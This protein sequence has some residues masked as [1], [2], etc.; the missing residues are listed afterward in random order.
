[1][2]FKLLFWSLLAMTFI[3][4]ADNDMPEKGEDNSNVNQETHPP[5]TFAVISDI[6]FGNN[7]GKGP[8]VKVPQ[9]LR[10]ITSRGELDALI[11][12]GDL[13]E[14]GNISEYDQ[15]VETF[16][17]TTVI[18]NPVKN[19]FFVMGNHDNFNS[20]GKS[21]FQTSLKPFNGGESYPLNNYQVIKGYP[22]IMVSMFDRHNND[23]DYPA[24]GTSTYPA[25][26]TNWLKESLE[27]ASQECP[28]K[29][30]FVFT[31]M[32]PR[33]TIYST[34]PELENGTAWCMKALNPILNKYPQ[35]VV[36]AGHNHYPM[37]DPRSIHQGANPNS[38][39]QN[40]YTVINTSS[41]TYA[42][43]YKDAFDDSIN[44]T[45]PVN[46]ADITEGLIVTELSNGDIEVKRYDTYR[47]EE[48][49]ADK[50]WILKA[51]FDGSQ[52]TYA[53]I[54]D[55]DDN[56]LNKEL[57]SG[58]DAPVFAD[59]AFL[60]LTTSPTAVM[61]KFPQASDDDCVFRY[62]FNVYEAATNT[63]VKKAYASSQFYMNS[64]RPER[65]TLT[66]SGLKSKTDYYIEA[67]A[68]DS[69]DNESAALVKEFTTK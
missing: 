5:L 58:G 18:V 64:A 66:I 51:P 50:R 24:Y 56:P 2:K 9:A 44:G 49:A 39:R 48:I 22:F 17:D 52:F 65:L 68:L 40:Y 46:Y 1:M 12:V 60:S 28:G 19:F 61:V 3:G 7:V 67:K 33:W 11:V 57:Y 14:N 69:Y 43:M 47:D 53:D 54:R 21:N 30:I 10:H 35:A 63:I 42:V 41:T 8:L 45:Y 32:P 13:T 27:K 20:N 15:L 55:K 16:Q 37:G 38:T 36:F 26:T 23:I 34:W 29:P 4:C 62:L 25:E 6:H 31:H 59:D